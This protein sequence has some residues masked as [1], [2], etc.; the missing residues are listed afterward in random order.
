M[1]RKKVNTDGEMGVLG[2]IVPFEGEYE[3]VRTE[4]GCKK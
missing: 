2:S 1:R 3:A 4:D